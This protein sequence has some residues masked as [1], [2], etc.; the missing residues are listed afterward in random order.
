M[1]FPNVP[2]ATLILESRVKE[3]MLLYSFDHPAKKCENLDFITLSLSVYLFKNHPTQFVSH[4]EST[5]PVSNSGFFSIQKP[6]EKADL[7]S[8]WE[9]SNFHNFLLE[10]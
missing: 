1:F 7:Q 10:V 4:W 8:G 9:N 5:E 6:K 3:E 2:G